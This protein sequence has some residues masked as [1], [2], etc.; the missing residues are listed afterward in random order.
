MVKIAVN[1]SKK[2]KKK[3][4]ERRK[5][6]YAFG[7]E[8]FC[9]FQFEGAYLRLVTA[10]ELF[11]DPGDPLSAKLLPFF[12]Y[13]TAEFVDEML[14]REEL[15]LPYDFWM[16]LD[17][18]IQENRSDEDDYLLTCFRHYLQ[19]KALEHNLPPKE[20]IAKLS[21]IKDSLSYLLV[22]S[23]SED[24]V[25]HFHTIFICLIEY[26]QTLLDGKNPEVYPV[27]FAWQVFHHE[28]NADTP[29]P[30]TKELFWMFSFIEHQRWGTLYNEQDPLRA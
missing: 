21:L 3:K 17:K 11:E 30:L 5:S 22:D 15:H 6:A 1:W 20:H 13:R 12:R 25:H 28:L 23:Y 29:H 9:H 10:S 24:L 8:N 4:F 7:I 18:I 2:A 27:A 19:Y 16:E 26:Y 14:K